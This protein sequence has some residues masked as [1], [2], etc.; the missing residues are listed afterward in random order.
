MSVPIAVTGAVPTTRMRSGVISD[1]PPIPVMPT[2]A[3]I[4]S[5]SAITTGSMPAWE[6]LEVLDQVGRQTRRR[7]PSAS[8][9]AGGPSPLRP[10]LRVR[11]QRLEPPRQLLRADVGEGDA[12]EHRAQVGP[13]GDPDVAQPLRRALVVELLG[14]RL[15]DVRQGPLD[16]PDDIGD[17]DLV[18]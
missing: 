14:R 13:D 18:G 12:L 17:G 2:S 7:D 16:R 5:P 15:V 1:A 4:P 6:P 10:H 11:Q 3:P 9:A 8:E